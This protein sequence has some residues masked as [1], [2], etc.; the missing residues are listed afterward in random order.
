[1]RCDGSFHEAS[2]AHFRAKR[3][4]GGV[5]E[6]R[7]RSQPCQLVPRRRDLWRQ[8]RLALE[9]GPLAVDM[10]FHPEARLLDAFAA[11]ALDGDEL[12]RVVGHLEVCE[13][14]RARI[15]GIVTGDGFLSRLRQAATLV[16]HPPAAPAER[17]RQAWALRRR[18][19]HD[20][21][22]L[23]AREPPAEEPATPREVANY[24]ILREVGRGGMGVVYLARHRGLQRLVALK[25]ILSGGFASEAERQRFQREAELAAR[26]EHPNIVRVYEAGV[27][28]CHP[29][30]VMEWVSGITLADRIGADPWSP[31]DAAGLI[32][33]LARAIDAAHRKGVVHRDLKPSNILLATDTSGEPSGP[34]AWAV[35]KIADFGLARAIEGGD[36]LTSTGL[37]IGTPEYMAPEQANRGARAGPTA[38]VYALGAMLYQLLTGRLP[39]MADTPIEVLQALCTTEPVAPRRLRPGLPRDLETITQK[40]ME[41]EPTRRYASAGELAEDLRRFLDGQPILAQPPTALTRIVKWARRRPSL[42]SLTAALA[43]VTLGAFTGLTALWAEAAQSRDRAKVAAL[44]AANRGDAERR[45]R[46]RAAVAA[47]EAQIELNNLDAARVFLEDA[48]EEYRDWEWRYLAAQLDNAR[49]IF[50]PQDGPAHIVTLA[51]SGK[52][53]AYSVAGDPDVRL[54]VPGERTDSKAL[55]GLEGSLTSIAFSPDGTLVAAGADDGVARVWGVADGRQAGVFS[56]DG[57]AVNRLVMAPDGSRLIACCQNG[58]SHLWDLANGRRLATFKS[59]NTHFDAESRR[60]ACVDYGSVDLRDAATG[61]SLRRWSVPGEI[62]ISA[63]VSPDGRRIAAGSTH[64]ANLVHLMDIDGERPPVVLAGHKN[65]VFS[66]VFSR[67]GR[68]LASISPD[69]TVRVWD[70][71]LAKVQAI[72]RGHSG[73]VR[74]LAF[75]P[76]GRRLVTVSSDGTAHVWDTADGTP[77]DVFRCGFPN[78]G[79]LSVSQD[80]SAVVMADNG[81]G[82]SYWDVDAGPQGGKLLGHTS[83]VY[84]IAFAPDGRTLASASW[85]GTVRLWD[86]RAG[87]EKTALRHSTFAVSSLAYSPDGRSIATIDQDGIVRAWDLA[88]D[89]PI[90]SRRLGQRRKQFVEYSV[91]FSPLGDLLAATGAQ[92]RLVVLIDAA[93]GDLRATFAG[94]EAEVSNAAFSPDGHHVASADWGGTLR[95][96]TTAGH[97]LM[98]VIQAHSEL[99]H[100]VIFSPDGSIVATASQDRSVRL[101]HVA[102]RRCLAT[103]RHGTVVYGM[104]FEPDATRLATAC[105]DGTVRFWDLDT[106]SEVAVLRGHRDYVHAIAFSPDGNRLATGSGDYS[107]CIWDSVPSRLRDQSPDLPMAR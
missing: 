36:R 90:W 100:R 88:T 5:A 102:T 70:T 107:I 74:D 77:L 84:D 56:H 89:A 101:W 21:A 25:M 71:T 54:R 105:N 22:P 45:A 64:P 48:P 29:Y 72:L 76:D 27:H 106:Y 82:V 93:T 10:P 97:E 50:H 99:I 34:M 66:L 12:D 16:G 18:I 31:S 75:S 26:L 92:D 9:D 47:A 28:D 98:A 61:E 62:F 6:S 33:T 8:N 58:D 96:W 19:Q 83:Y 51:P 60:M 95:L 87:R 81:G 80:A 15:D 104:A 3:A 69:K 23:G 44:E 94:H 78:V 59:H 17:R 24:E 85:D 52:L 79:G 73:P 37:A 35:P 57:G 13:T 7:S 42:A 39:F 40:A 49:A 14:C 46:Y 63:A 41:R 67:D 103:L 1:M 32:E 53:I 55:R 2:I 38:D 4:E 11:G 68:M 65:S 91:A 20:T 43:V 86:T 30:L